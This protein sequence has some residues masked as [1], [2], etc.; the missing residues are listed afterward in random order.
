MT[1]IFQVCR[2]WKA[3][4]V[5]STFE[6]NTDDNLF[7]SSRLVFPDSGSQIHS[8]KKIVRMKF[9]V[10]QR[11][12][13]LQ[14]S[15]TGEV[16]KKSRMRRFNINVILSPFFVS[17]QNKTE[18]EILK[19]THIYVLKI[20]KYNIIRYFQLKRIKFFFSLDGN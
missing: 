3:R 8:H 15:L 12:A 20:C 2:A 7:Y 11:T 1:S 6:N 14:T 10:Y 17:R 9:S 4:S 18:A 5:L 19:R 16:G 13:H